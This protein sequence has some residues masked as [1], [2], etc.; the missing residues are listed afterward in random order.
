MSVSRQQVLGAYRN[1]LKAQRQTFKGDWVALAAAREK[2]YT[3]F[4]NKRNETDEA[5]IKEQLELAQQ[6]ASLLRHNLAQAVQVEGRSDLYKLRLT[7]DHELG[8]NET[9]RQASKMRRLKNQQA[10]AK[11][12]SNTDNG[13]DAPV[14]CGG[15]GH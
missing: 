14:C 7:G 2:T 9:L 13:C 3:E 4:S 1:L 11:N 6:V 12:Q 8:D 5:K 10:Q 15:G